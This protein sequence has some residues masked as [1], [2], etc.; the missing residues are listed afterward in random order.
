MALTD[1]CAVFASVNESAVRR[2]ISQVT[3][4]RPSLVNYGSAGVQQ[5]PGLLC[6]AID[7]HPVAIAR[8]GRAHL[9]VCPSF[10]G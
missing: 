8:G 6:L 7:A 4:Q 5:R 1:H 9:R 3:R 10:A 2:V